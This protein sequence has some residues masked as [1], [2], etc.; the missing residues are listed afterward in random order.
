MRKT[1]F[2]LL[3]AVALTGCAKDNLDVAP[4][5]QAQTTK[6]L[7]RLSEQDVATLKKIIATSRLVETAPP[8]GTQG[9][10]LS[11][12]GFRYYTVHF[13][14]V[15]DING[16]WVTFD[17]FVPVDGQIATVLRYEY[18]TVD[19]TFIDGATISSVFE[20]T[21]INSTFT[22]GLTSVNCFANV[23]DYQFAGV[24]EIRYANEQTG[25]VSTISVV[26]RYSGSFNNT[27]IPTE[28]EPFSTC[29]VAALPIKPT[30][31]GT[32]TGGNGPGGD[33]TGTGYGDDTG[34]TG[35]GWGQGTPTGWS[36]GGSTG[37]GSTGGGQV[38]NET[39][40]TNPP[41]TP[42]QPPR[43]NEPAV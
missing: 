20:G 38:D 32:G 42:P 23:I 35:S 6:G 37:G 28:V 27:Y 4:A 11:G 25:L 19:N 17:N 33:G 34:S 12:L 16:Q 2:A 31:G 14:Q 13:G 26:K 43:D 22:Q 5:K 10:I 3:F 15:Q 18:C 36:G 9:R 7:P 21:A 1:Y 41:T 40:P 30:G 24:W 39:D 8:A 29:D